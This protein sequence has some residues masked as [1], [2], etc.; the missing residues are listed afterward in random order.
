VIIALWELCLF[1]RIDRI[2]EIH[3]QDVDT[4]RGREIARVRDFLLSPVLLRQLFSPTLWSG[5]WSSYA[6]YDESYADRRSFGFTI[7]IG[8]GFTT[9]V[10]SLLFIHAMSFGD[11]PARAVGIVGLLLFYQ[12]WYGTVLYVVSF[13]LNRRHVGHPRSHIAL[14]V[15][16]SNGVWLVAPDLGLY[17]SAVLVYTD[18]YALFVR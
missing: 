3:R 7:D 2:A 8:N 5:I 6:V 12:M 16:L 11:L 10:P 1:A 9:L 13:F 15:G 4:Y 14:I 17:A 18:S